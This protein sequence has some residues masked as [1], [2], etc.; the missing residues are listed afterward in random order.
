MHDYVAQ[1][2]LTLDMYKSIKQFKCLFLKK[3]CD[4][5]K[6]KNQKCDK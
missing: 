6:T 1:L 3:Y 5:S 4:T 2:E